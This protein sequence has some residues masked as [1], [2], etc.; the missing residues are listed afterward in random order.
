MNKALVH[1]ESS[2]H[3]TGVTNRSKERIEAKFHGHFT[4]FGIIEI[5]NYLS[6]KSVHH[7]KNLLIDHQNR[8][9][10]FE[11]NLRS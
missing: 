4:V 2:G 11:L 5:E 6:W 1:Q 7:D 10:I 8:L 9:V 3:F